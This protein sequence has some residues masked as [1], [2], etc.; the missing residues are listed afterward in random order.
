M[1]KSSDERPEWAVKVTQLRERLSISQAGLARRLNC[2]P[3]AVSRWERGEHEPPAAWYIQLGNLAEAPDCWYFWG[4][5][6]LHSA[7][8]LRMVPG[9]TEL[10]RKQSMGGSSEAAAG[11]GALKTRSTPNV[12]AIPLVPVHV[13][14]PGAGDRVLNL[15]QVEP[16][17]MLAAP[18]DWCPNPSQTV[19]VRVHGNSMQPLIHDG[20]IVAVDTSN[21]ERSQLYGSVVIA[22]NKESGLVVSR[23]QLFEGV[24]VFVPDNRE[25]ESTPVEK[26]QSWRILGKVLW[27]IG[28]AD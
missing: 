13:G 23:L 26:G 24:E 16:E 17:R 12:V 8:L 4:R 21:R 28:L 15:D 22:W 1:K 2:S 5:A 6:G 25:Y 20:Y 7:D 3:M 9:A 11:A 19:C 18:S 10:Q 14:P 27:W